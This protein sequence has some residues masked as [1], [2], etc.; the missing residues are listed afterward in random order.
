MSYFKYSSQ[1]VSVVENSNASSFGAEDC[2]FESRWIHIFYL[3]FS[4]DSRSSKLRK[5]N[6]N[7]IKRDILPEKEVH[8]DIIDI[9]F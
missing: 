3:T 6:T 2:W 5:A 1:A 4:L 9:T 7:E 8:R